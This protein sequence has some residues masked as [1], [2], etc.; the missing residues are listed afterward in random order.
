M[1]ENQTSLAILKGRRGFTWRGVSFK[2]RVRE[3]GEEDGGGGGER[4]RESTDIVRVSETQ[5]MKRRAG[6][7]P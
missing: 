2:E 6:R 1:F 7:R 5:A 4:R 3:T